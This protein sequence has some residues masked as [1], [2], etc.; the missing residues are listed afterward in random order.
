M[1]EQERGKDLVLEVSE[2]ELPV[3]EYDIVFLVREVIN[4]AIKFSTPGTQIIVKSWTEN[5]S[6]FL[7]VTGYG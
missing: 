6:Y 5:D 7:E 4:N 1:N 3:F 2:A